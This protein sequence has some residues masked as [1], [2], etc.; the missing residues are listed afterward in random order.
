M[1]SG[2]TPGDKGGDDREAIKQRG[3]AA[4]RC[5]LKPACINVTHVLVPVI[6]VVQAA[7]SSRDGEDLLLQ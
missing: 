7:D 5:L 2:Y 3:D 4:A 6:K 1:P